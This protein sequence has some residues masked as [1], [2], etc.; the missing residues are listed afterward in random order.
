MA[1]SGNAQTIGLATSRDGIRWQFNNQTDLLL[2]TTGWHNGAVLNP[3][4]VVSGR[5]LLLW[6]SGIDNHNGTNPMTPYVAGIGFATCGAVLALP[7][8]TTTTSQTVTTTRTS[9]S[10]ST[11][12]STVFSTTTQMKTTTVLQN[13]NA[14]TLEVAIAAVVGASVALFASILVILMRLR[15]RPA[16]PK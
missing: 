9:T 16:A 12:I 2:S 5:Q 8:V 6:Y 11:S 14:S 7:P 3:S 15:S 4:I 13:S 1:F 10:I